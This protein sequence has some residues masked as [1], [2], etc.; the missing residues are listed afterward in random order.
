[1]SAPFSGHLYNDTDN[2]FT[3]QEDLNKVLCWSESWGLPLNKNK[4]VV[5]HIG[6]KNTGMSYH[7]DGV[8]LLAVLEHNDL[9]VVVSGNLTWANHISKQI[10]KANSR[11]YILHQCFTKSNLP[12]MSK[13]FKIFV[14]PVLEFAHPVWF[15]D[16]LQDLEVYE[17]VQRRFTRWCFGY[18]RPSY[19]DRLSTMNLISLSNRRL[20]GDLIYT[21][22][23]LKLG[24][25]VTFFEL[26]RDDRLRGHG[27]T[28]TTAQY[29]ATVRQ[30]FLSV[31]V[32]NYWNMLPIQLIES[33]SVN[34]FKNRLDDHFG[35]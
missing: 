35:W 14:R 28:L 27:L 18:R 31:R 24:G 23:V 12:L 17:R 26:R 13:L 34:I 9:G 20:R 2:S 11:M 10:R 19:S 22:K 8:R 3:L 32:V 15:P 1:V 29:R 16:R 21:F 30:N 7:I 33:E 5:L 4:C 6:K 25:D